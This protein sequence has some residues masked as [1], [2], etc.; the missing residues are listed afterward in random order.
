LLAEFVG[1]LSQLNPCFC[2]QACGR[3]L[4]HRRPKPR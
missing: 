3:L 1:I 4:G 2:F